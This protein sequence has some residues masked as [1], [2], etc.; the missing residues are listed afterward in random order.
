MKPIHLFQPAYH[1]PE[2]LALIEQCLESGWTGAGQLVHDFEAAWK[3][4]TGLSNAHFVSSA[5]A[6]LHLAVQLLKDANDWQI[7][8]QIIT[9]PLTFVS[10]NHAI[11]YA[12]L[13]P[14]FADVDEYL[15]LSPESVLERIGPKTR[16]VMFVGLGGNVG[17]YPEIAEICR[18]RGLKIILDAAHMAGSRWLGRHVGYDADVV[19]YSFHAVKNLPM[20]DGGMV[21]FRDAA[22]DK[23][24]RVMSWM[25]INKDTFTRSQGGNGYSWEYDVQEI[26]WKYN[27]NN[28]MAAMGLA[29]LPHLDA[30][31][32][33]RCMIAR[34][35]NQYLP[36]NITRVPHRNEDESSRHLF[37]ILIPQRDETILKLQERE[38][39]PGVHYR[40]NTDYPMYKY[41][42]C[43]NAEKASKEVLS[44]P[45]H[46]KMSMDDIRRV[47]NTIG[48]ICESTRQ[49]A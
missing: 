22:L 34:R 40:T 39:Y 26:G 17:R 47:A 24:A 30:E 49:A 11:M 35:Y 21:C 46:L 48:E 8:D 5:T 4:Y 7:G 2:T 27:G 1:I 36:A 18:E 37:Q 32:D 38:I 14:M 16:A 29:G 43:P 42:H 33:D 31:N 44:L 41:A 28:I 9:T 6:G 23:Q 45:L 12:G 25:G 13:V 20:A 19:V 3:D 10:T 15:T